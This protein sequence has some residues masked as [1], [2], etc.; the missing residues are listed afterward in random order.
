MF[1]HFL[2]ENRKVAKIFKPRSG[3]AYQQGLEDEAEEKKEQRCAETS[4]E[5]DSAMPG[6][7]EEVL[8]ATSMEVRWRGRR[9]DRF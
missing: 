4:V 8:K 2:T 1:Y 5:T 6:R 9:T 3:K 7:T